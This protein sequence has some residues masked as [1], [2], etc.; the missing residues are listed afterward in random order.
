MPVTP[1]SGGGGFSQNHFLVMVI[2]L[3]DSNYIIG[4][5]YNNKLKFH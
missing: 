3:A 5:Y 4:I 2:L 1:G